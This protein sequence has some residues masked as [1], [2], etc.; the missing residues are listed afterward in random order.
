ML[1]GVCFAGGDVDGEIDIYATQLGIPSDYVN[2]LSIRGTA[3]GR[4]LLA[5]RDGSLYEMMYQAE[6][7]WFNK[8]CRKVNHTQ[9]GIVQLLVPSFMRFG[10]ADALVDI[11]VDDTRNIVY[12]LSE[13]SVITVWDLG[14][15]GQSMR[16][17]TVYSNAA[18]EATRYV[19]RGLYLSRDQTLPIRA[20]AAV[21][22]SESASVHLMAITY[23]G[24]RLFFS[25]RASRTSR[26]ST[27]TLV[28]ARVP[29][30]SANASHARSPAP[31]SV[32]TAFYARGVTLM[33][34]E[35]EGEELDTVVAV[36]PDIGSGEA[37]YGSS[38]AASHL[39]LHGRVWAFAEDTPPAAACR[40][41]VPGTNTP[42]S[43]AAEAARAGI[44]VSLSDLA[45][46]HAHAPREFLALTV[47]GLHRI[48]QLRPVDVLYQLLTSAQGQDTDALAH[49]FHTYGR[50]QACAMCLILATASPAHRALRSNLAM[51]GEHAGVGSPR[52]PGQ[53]SHSRVTYSDPNMASYAAR[54]FF[55]HG[56]APYF[57]TRQDMLPSTSVDIGRAVTM[58][59]LCY[60]GCHNGLCLYVSR[61]LQPVWRRTLV[62]AQ[63]DARFAPDLLHDIESA[64]LSLASFLERNEAFTAPPPQ[65]SAAANASTGADH[66]DGP[67]RRLLE[68]QSRSVPAEAH[69]AEQTSVH[70]MFQLVRR[71]TDA[72]AFLA[73]VAEHDMRACVDLMA[74]D[75]QRRLGQLTFA[76][77]V[78]VD[79]LGDAMRSRCIQFF[80]PADMLRYKAYENLERA[81]T[82][83]DEGERMALLN[84]SLTRLCKIP[85]SVPLASVCDQFRA[86]GFYTGILELVLTCAHAV[87]P[88]RAGPQ[89]DAHQ[90]RLACYQCLFA[91]L[92]D[93]YMPEGLAPR[94]PEAAGDALRMTPEERDRQR[95]QVEAKALASTDMTFHH[96]FYRWAIDHALGEHLLDLESPFLEGFL[97]HEY[98][99][100]LEE[101]DSGVDVAPVAID[102][103]W[104]F[105]VRNHKFAAAVLVLSKLA[106]KRTRAIGLDQRVRY[107]SLALG[108]AK[109]SG[110]S[111]KDAAQV[112]QELSEKM[113]VAQIQ[114]KIARELAQLDDDA[115]A[116][117]ETAASAVD[118][119]PLGSMPDAG[120]VAGDVRA[121]AASLEYE[122]FNISDLY[123]EYAV[124]YQLWESALAIMHCSGHS[125]EALIRQIWER[126]ISDQLSGYHAEHHLAEVVAGKV[127]QLGR[128]Y[129]PHAEAVFPVDYIASLLEQLVLQRHVH[130]A[131]TWG[132]DVLA[133]IGLTHGA[134][135]D[136]YAGL[137]RTK[138]TIWAD[139]A[140][141]T[142]LVGVLCAVIERWLDIVRERRGERAQLASRN[143]EDAIGQYLVDLQSVPGAGDTVMDLVE[144]L[145]RLQRT[146][147]Q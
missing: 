51:L 145:K 87:D 84:E 129:Y 142:H 86:M 21:P 30:P 89:T 18:R 43:E 75:Q 17:V 98:E 57:D 120:N 39:R 85:L 123:N 1:L 121:A 141:Q 138:P 9:G 79:L 76:Q 64:L 72:V 131:P 95:I 70:A 113:E 20:I 135:F 115:L 37:Q 106:E 130:A 126:I 32:H 47:S 77:L 128:S 133:A 14:T 116:A 7:T 137:Y 35:S 67:T 50:D 134:L 125:D 52:T 94:S 118:A 101:L 66:T 90:S 22:A 31:P 13:R 74:Q 59:D 111:L 73:I 2:I 54:A 55:K 100:A 33:A 8:R 44:V 42:V 97:R 46:Q 132:A 36:S 117:L 40:P 61:I 127:I 105:F 81:R 108:N 56:G 80:G 122:L 12:T 71:A 34:D 92:T 38:E 25:T 6:D 45:T 96:A 104:Q 5:G 24:I 103:L 28:N 107:L 146:L 91:S 139:Q 49:F 147:Q 63:R 23:T 60:S 143:V 16:R 99:A 19:P 4:I 58:P 88:Q 93:L 53:A 82:L 41:T 11:V 144:R 109:S 136:V 114:V 140:A 68:Y 62:T 78:S 27:L 48:V 112:L 29:P 26:P 10:Q 69:R 3:A 124:R 110:Q 102:L 15:D 119:R 65:N 83:R